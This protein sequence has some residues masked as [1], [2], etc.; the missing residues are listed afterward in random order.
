VTAGPRV[1]DQLG[2]GSGG[3]LE[4]ILGEARPTPGLSFGRATGMAGATMRVAPP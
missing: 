4:G 2:E 3:H 1:E